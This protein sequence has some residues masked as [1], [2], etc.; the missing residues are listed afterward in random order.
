MSTTYNFPNHTRNDT[1]AA[2]AFVYKRNGVVI[3]LTGATIAM[4]LRLVKTQT[5]PDLSLSTATSG[6][7]ITTAA[8]GEWEVDAQVI[9]IAA[10]VYFQDVQLTE[11]SGVISTFT[12]GTW[13]ILQ[14]VTYT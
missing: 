4:M 10:G 2:Q 6:I 9:S 8:A 12:S 11:A 13:T 7:T 1:F 3:D 5:T 14:D